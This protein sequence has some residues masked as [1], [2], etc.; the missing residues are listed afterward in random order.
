M[1]AWELN[2]SWW[3]DV[4]FA[5][6]AQK[7]G[8]EKIQD[9]LPDFDENSPTIIPNDYNKYAE[10]PIGL[11]EVDRDFRKFSGAIGTHIGSNNWVVSGG[12]SASGKPI[13][14][15]DPHLL[16]TVPAKW[17]IVSIKSS[18][19]NV[20]GFTLPGVPGIIIGKNE[21]I[22]WVVT[23]LMADDTDFYIE[24]CLQISKIHFLPRSIISIPHLNVFRLL[25]F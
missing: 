24:K 4:A 19:L 1:I 15:N 20:D 10:I 5:H 2:I 23:N 9:I 25:K 21:N 6:L 8:E 3:S 16:F 11:I 17:Y 13:I 14:A 18:Q 22:S 7:L 12:K